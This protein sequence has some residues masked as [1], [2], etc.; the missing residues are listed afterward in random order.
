MTDI[1]QGPFV[2][3]PPAAGYAD[4]AVVGAFGGGDDAVGMPEGGPGSGRGGGA[5]GVVAGVRGG[6]RMVCCKE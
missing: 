6:M 2:P 1:N 5:V 3:A 4:Q